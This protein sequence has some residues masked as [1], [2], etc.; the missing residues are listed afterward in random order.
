MLRALPQLLTLAGLLALAACN[1]S[2]KVSWR[3]ETGNEGRNQGGG[4]V[5]VV[6]NSRAY[7][8][9]AEGGGLGTSAGP[10]G[11]RGRLISVS[12]QDERGQD[13][14]AHLAV[15]SDLAVIER[16]GRHIEIRSPAFP[17][18]FVVPGGTAHPT[19]GA[20]LMRVDVPEGQSPLPGVTGP[21]SFHF[22]V[23]GNLVLYE[24]AT[25]LFVFQEGDQPERFDPATVRWSVAPGGDILR[26]TTAQG[27]RL[28]AAPQRFAE[29]QR[30]QYLAGVDRVR[31]FGPRGELTAE[32][33]ARQVRISDGSDDV[34]LMVDGGGS[35]GVLPLR[36]RHLLVIEGR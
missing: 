22:L 27:P 30:M 1:D 8:G 18:T 25:R 28:F 3:L 17:S 36:N 11:D 21:G 15:R 32:V 6:R 20:E 9:R 34:R 7:G 2:D 13:L 26:L 33:P 29:D 16:P 14:V 24:G 5:I 12:G 10:G 4:G 23:E 31:L 35:A 19:L